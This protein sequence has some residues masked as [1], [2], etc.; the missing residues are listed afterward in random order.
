MTLGDGEARAGRGNMALLARA[1]RERWPITEDIRQA[2]VNQMLV[3][4]LKKETDTR[5]KIAATKVL[6]AMDSINARREATEAR[7]DAPSITVQGNAVIQLDKLTLDERRELLR[8]RRK[9]DGDNDASGPAGGDRAEP[10]GA[11]G[12]DSPGV[13]GG[14][15]ALGVAGDRAELPPD[16]GTAP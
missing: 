1:V 8:L 3:V 12:V 4:L 7:A 15:P 2:A 6:A 14:L 10:S 16:L 11:G 9:L 5:N 13:A